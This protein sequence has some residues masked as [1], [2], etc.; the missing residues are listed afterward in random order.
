MRRAFSNALEG[1]PAASTR[2]ITSYGPARAQVQAA[3][4]QQQPRQSRAP[5]DLIV[6][7]SR[8]Q[9]CHD[10]LPGELSRTYF[11]STG[12]RWVG[13]GGQEPPDPNKANLGKSEH[14]IS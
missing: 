6:M 4:P 13:I 9:N 7:G 1:R 12:V 5:S 11:D 14:L 8:A 10:S 3:T 2:S